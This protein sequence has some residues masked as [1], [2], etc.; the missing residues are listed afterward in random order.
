MGSEQPRSWSQRLKEFLGSKEDDPTALP[1]V[2]PRDIP[3]S[4]SLGSVMEQDSPLI[5]PASPEDIPSSRPPQIAIPSGDRPR[6]T[7]RRNRQAPPTNP[8]HLD[9]PT[10]G[11]E[12]DSQQKSDNANPPG[13]N[14]RSTLLRICITPPPPPKD[15]QTESSAANQQSAAPTTQRRRKGRPL[16]SQSLQLEIIE[17]EQE[18]PE[19]PARD[20]EDEALYRALHEEFYDPYG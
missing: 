19:R 16:E 10:E 1:Y 15:D 2:N 13:D 7:P 6:F 5:L 3:R 8:P 20:P 12:Q 18:E 4:K 11:D 17:P 9:E 14:T